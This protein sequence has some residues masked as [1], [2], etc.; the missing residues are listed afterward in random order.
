MKPKE[1]SEFKKD[2]EI[3]AGYPAAIRVKDQI[4]D[5][6]EAVIKA[7]YDYNLNKS[8][9]FDTD[10]PLAK[11]RAAVFA[12]Y[13]RLRPKFKDGEKQNKEKGTGIFALDKA[14]KEN[15]KLDFEKLFDYFQQLN[16]K[17]EELE[18]TKFE[19]PKTDP[20]KAM[21]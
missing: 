2:K 13:Q 12:L 15:T 11:F 7:L 14:Q 8:S 16:D 5:C 18:I 17:I 6:R 21:A 9:G 20:T 4:L 19:M 10:K 3:E 1:D